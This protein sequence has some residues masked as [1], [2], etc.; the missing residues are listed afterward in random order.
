M[1]KSFLKAQIKKDGKKYFFIAS[2]A[3]I[4]RQGESID[5]A[6]WDLANYKLNPVIL[7]A[8]DYSSLP[9]GKGIVEMVDNK[10]TVEIVFATMAENPEG[11]KVQNLV[12]AGILTALSVGF[13]P[14][15]RNGN[16]I[17]KSELLE[18]S[19]VPVPAN[20]EA[21]ALVR[22]MAGYEAMA[23]ALQKGFD[24][25]DVIPDEV[26][27]LDDVSEVTTAEEEQFADELG[28]SIDEV[29][30]ID[31]EEKAIKGISRKS[32]ETL[33]SATKTLTTALEEMLVQAS[34]PQG[35]SSV[36][37]RSQF[38]VIER[39]SIE[40]LR[41]WVRHSDKANERALSAIK[42]TLE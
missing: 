31:E 9:I 38:V 6:G 13:I 25:G 22:T 40:A 10:L 33:L 1:N 37:E 3:T 27:I 14:M 8:H 26:N 7:W 21:L 18:I 41:D 34:E 4:D 5:Q 42:E 15:E 12:D 39:S 20:P 35:N 17:T 28:G 19:V 11:V 29:A 16:I 30:P 23:V 24:D 2:T 32:I 36:M